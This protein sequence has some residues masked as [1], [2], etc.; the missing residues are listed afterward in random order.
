MNRA[1]YFFAMGWIRSITTH[2]KFPFELRKARH[3]AAIDRLN[4]LPRE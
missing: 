1:Q 2:S 4:N 3:L